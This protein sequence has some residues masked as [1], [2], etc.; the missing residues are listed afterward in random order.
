MKFSF[1]DT[2]ATKM[3]EAAAGACEI[4]SIAHMATLRARAEFTYAYDAAYERGMTEE[5]GNYESETCSDGANCCN[6]GASNPANNAYNTF[7]DSIANIPTIADGNTYLECVF[8]STLPFTQESWRN[9]TDLANQLQDDPIMDVLRGWEMEDGVWLQDSPLVLRF[10]MQ[11]VIL[12]PCENGALRIWHGVLDDQTDCLL[13]ANLLPNAAHLPNDQQSR[14]RRERCCIN[15]GITQACWIPYSPLF[16]LIG[17][18]T[19]A[20]DWLTL[21]QRMHAGCSSAT[22]RTAVP[23]RH[24]NASSRQAA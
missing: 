13:E 15:A 11:D 20:N 17:S 8:D 9:L 4:A 22:I 14:L 16:G 19:T 2:V 10:E 3:H 5:W 21:A 7:T 1:I 18:Y 6:Y 23:T 12:Q 24:A